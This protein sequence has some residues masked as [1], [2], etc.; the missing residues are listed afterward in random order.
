MKAF[1][2][3]TLGLLAS[4]FLQSCTTTPSTRNLAKLPVA[5]E[6]ST[7]AYNALLK[8]YVTSDGVD[9]VSWSQSNQDKQ[10]LR[11][12]ALFYAQTQ[13]PHNDQQAL[14]WY[15][16]AYNALILDQILSRWPNKGPLDASVLFFHGRTITVA[17][18]Q[19]SF[20]TLEQKIIRPQFPDPRIHFALN[21]ASRS[22]PP[23]QGEPFQ[24]ESLPN[25]LH[26]VTLEFLNQNPQAFIRGGDEIK[27]SKI[28][29]WYEEDF[30]GREQL[31]PFINRYLTEPLPTD[32]PISFLKYDWSLNQAP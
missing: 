19:M 10:K 3:L 28:F 22:C 9:Y 14:P 25:T 31:I 15:L 8:K 13:P 18:Q 23:L 16:N 20:Q 1:L 27:L 4:F 30:G 21:C 29:K 7:P 17:G 6:A 12:V 24:A 26:E 5:H 2:L 32:S 11:E